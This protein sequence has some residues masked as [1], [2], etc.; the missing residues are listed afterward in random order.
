[1]P[2]AAPLAAKMDLTGPS[3]PLGRPL[4]QSEEVAFAA[5]GAAARF[6]PWLSGMAA[7]CEVVSHVTPGARL[8]GA[9]RVLLPVDSGWGSRDVLGHPLWSTVWSSALGGV[10]ETMLRPGAPPPLSVPSV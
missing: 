9:G 6:R 8:R 4:A 7:R 5:G 2:F 1:M 3:G 10:A